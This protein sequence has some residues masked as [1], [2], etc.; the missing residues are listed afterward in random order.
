MINKKVSKEKFRDLW[1]SRQERI[2]GNYDKGDHVKI[3]Y[4]NQWL[5]CEIAEEKNNTLRILLAKY[6]PY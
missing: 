2:E 1:K 4:E 3:I 5:L 6:L